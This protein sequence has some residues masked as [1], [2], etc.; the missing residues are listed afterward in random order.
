MAEVLVCK[1]GEI[2]EGGVRVV[3][4]GEVEIGVRLR[5]VELDGGD[6]IVGGAQPRQLGD[7]GGDIAQARGHAREASRPVDGASPR[8]GHPL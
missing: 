5:L 6:R 3:T 1:D 8:I 7:D 4:A 2:A